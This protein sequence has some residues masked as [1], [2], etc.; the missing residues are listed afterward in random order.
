M[1]KELELSFGSLRCLEAD[2]DDDDDDNSDDDDV[3]D[4]DD[5]DDETNKFGPVRCCKR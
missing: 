1:D 4:D 3:V 2:D 5:D